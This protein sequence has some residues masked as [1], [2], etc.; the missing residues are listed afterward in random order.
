MIELTL[1]PGAE[2]NRVAAETTRRMAAFPGLNPAITDV[3]AAATGEFGAGAALRARVYGEN[4][5][6]LD[7]ATKAVARAFRGLPGAGTVRDETDALTP[8]VRADID[9][10]RLALFGLT[11][12]DV[13]DTV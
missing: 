4:L 13:L 3:G 5:D 11:S 7:T 8:V 9:F 1:A 2:R 12:A 10:Q 6:D